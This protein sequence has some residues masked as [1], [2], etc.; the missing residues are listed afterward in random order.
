MRGSDIQVIEPTLEGYSGHCHALV[1]SFVGAAVPLPIELWSGKGSEGMAFRPGVTVHPYFQRRIRLPQMLYLLRRLLRRSAP[2]LITTARTSDLALLGFAAS[3]RL[4]PNRAF[5]YFH[6]VRA[7]PGKL[8]VLRR[9]AARQPDAVILGTTDSVVEVFRRCG[10]K[11]VLLL[12]YPGPQPPDTAAAV[13]FRQLLYAG[14]AR[15]DK[16]FR[17]VVDLVQLLAAGN[18]SIPITVQI[19]AD[20]YGKYDAATREDIARLKATRYAPLRLIEHTPSPEA[21]AANF[22]G[23]ICLQP[24]VRSEFRDR[25]SGVT[26]DALA[27]ACP[28]VVTAGTW[29]A[30]LVGRF[31]AGIA[32]ADPRAQSLYDAVRAIRADY[33]RYQAGAARAGRTRNRDSWAPLLDR[34][35]P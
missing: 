33:P 24:Y 12:P 1:S 5:L 18:E 6:W 31:D 22:A 23:G 26:L 14:A 34:L 28:V 7:T 17:A 30:E 16:G 4:S 15:Q 3:G 21:Y 20:H 25:V 2:I 13:P 27:H 9:L 19:T 11:D 10:F 32:L 8:R 35:G 29:S